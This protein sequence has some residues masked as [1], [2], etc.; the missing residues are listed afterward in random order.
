MAVKSLKFNW[1]QVGS[2]Q[3]SDGCGEDYSWVT[4]GEK[5]V[6]LIEENI[7]KSENQC[8]NYLVH[9]ENGEKKRIFNPNIVEYLQ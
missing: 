6:T 5:G 2:V 3:D 1:H 4:I 9:Y 7:P 8:C